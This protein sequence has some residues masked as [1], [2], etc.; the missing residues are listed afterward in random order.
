MSANKLTDTQLVLLSAAAQ[1][2]EGAIELASDLK[3]G[4]ANFT[5]LIIAAEAGNRAGL[6]A[7]LTNGAKPGAATDKGKTALKAAVNGGYVE[8]VEVL[9]K[10][11]A[12]PDFDAGFPPSPRQLSRNKDAALR[13][14]FD[15]S[16]SV[17]D[18][19]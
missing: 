4:A 6:E 19:K 13:A 16:K 14:L 3:G 9:L 11:G 17:S 5:A 18:K 7:L 12:D 15:G 2:P 1:H 10:A 8:L